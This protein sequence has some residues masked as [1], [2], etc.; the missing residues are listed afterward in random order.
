[1]DILARFNLCEAIFW[2]VVSLILLLFGVYREKNIIG[3]KKIFLF[4]SIILVLFG[5]SDLIEI[6]TG[7]WWRPAWLLLF[8]AICVIGIIIS[9]VFLRK[10]LRPGQSKGN[11]TP[12]V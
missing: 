3:Q 12:G 7:A 8:K 4:L 11:Y 1:M 5:I 10:K 9:V 6:K 2:F